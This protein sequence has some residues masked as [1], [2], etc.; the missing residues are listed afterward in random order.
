MS[1]TSSGTRPSDSAAVAAEIAAA[2]A[3][4][5]AKWLPL[6]ES[7][8]KPINTYRVIRD[9]GIALIMDIK[10]ETNVAQNMASPMSPFFYTCSL[11]H[12]MPIS[13]VIYKLLVCVH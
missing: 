10:Q 8:E 13:L 5:L 11:M 1:F 12:C 9:D 4:W 2:K 3:E 6:L 7:D